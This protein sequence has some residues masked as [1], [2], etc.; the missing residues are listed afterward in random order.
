MLKRILTAVVLL[1]VVL[2]TLFGLR[3]FSLFY[4]DALI[5]ICMGI[6][7][8]EMYGAFRR[9]QYKPMAIPLIIAVLLI[10]PAV[11][12]LREAGIIAVV[13]VCAMIALAE[14]T[15]NHKYELK[16][17]L[18]TS[19]IFIYPIAMLSI[20]FLINGK[21]TIGDNPV[22]TNSGD[23]LGIML[24]LFIPVFTD[25]FAYFTG[26]AIGG[27]KLCPEISPKKTIAGAVGGL[28][29]GMVASVAVFLLFDF[30]GV[31]DSMKNVHVFA[32]TSSIGASVAVYLVIGL[33][34]GIVCEVGDLAASWIKRKAGIKD[35]GKIF[36]GHGGIMDRLDSILFILPVIYITFTVIN[37]VK[38]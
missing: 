2:G 19:F 5:L 11:W 4:V 9:A 3:Q 7:V 34:G 18:S 17:F 36:P 29:G 8:Y 37:A 24:A 22:N 21:T 10:Y 12:F 32:L 25:T 14:F 20:L 15:F 31:F 38:A 13:A 23:M 35:F 6:G 1:A 33:I 16:D 26:M 30:Y 28:I 27:K